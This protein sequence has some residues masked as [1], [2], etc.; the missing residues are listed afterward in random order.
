[1]ATLIDIAPASVVRTAVRHE[2][3]GW[4]TGAGIVGIS[5]PLLYAHGR[6]TQ[7]YAKQA[8]MEVLNPGRRPVQRRP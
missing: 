3:G 7:T 4:N 6:T 5:E 1:M 2:D 8:D